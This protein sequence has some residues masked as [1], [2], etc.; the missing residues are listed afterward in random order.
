MHIISWNVNGIRSVERKGFC[1]WLAASEVDILGVQEIKARPEQLSAALR[2]PAGYHVSW[3]PAVKPGYSGVATFS[4]QPPLR[5]RRG[6]GLEVFDNEGRVLI[7]D[8]PALTFVNCYFPS[9]SA[10]PHRVAHK[11][12][13]YEHMTRFLR[14]LL[15]EGR[16]LV[17]VGDLNTAFAPIDLARPKENMRTS[18]F[19]PEERTALGT[20]FGAGLVD[21]FRQRWPERAAYSWWA[22]YPPDLRARNMGWRL[23]YILVTPDLAERIVE[24]ET[25]PEV[26]GSDHAPVSLII[27]DSR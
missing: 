15:E 13:F 17:L 6:I 25:H 3:L 7:S 24:A 16:P 10:G 11:L 9:G 23:D 8:F 2:E 4:K 20:L 27:A 12:A 26:T 1:N 18:G 21:S 22:Q 14:G 5:E 19:L